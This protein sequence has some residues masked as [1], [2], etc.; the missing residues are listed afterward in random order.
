MSKK[1]QLALVEPYHKWQEIALRIFGFCIGL[2]GKPSIAFI[3]IVDDKEEPIE[4]T[5]NDLKKMA[6]ESAENRVGNIQQPNNQT[7]E[8]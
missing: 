3:E 1:P 2:R 4:P 5:I 7:N 6:E 8:E